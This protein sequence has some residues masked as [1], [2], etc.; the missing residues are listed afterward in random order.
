L[1]MCVRALA[2]SDRIARCMGLP[3][4]KAQEFAR[5]II[6]PPGSTGLLLLPPPPCA[7][8]TGMFPPNLAHD[9]PLT[10]K[11]PHPRRVPACPDRRARVYPD[12]RLVQRPVR[13]CRGSG[14]VLGHVC[15]WGGNERL[16]RR[17]GCWAADGRALLPGD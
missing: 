4:N 5:Q 13:P 10:H 17:A 9:F 12:A 1:L 6:S 11:P 14:G 7:P 3:S 2:K 16:R 8:C 15:L